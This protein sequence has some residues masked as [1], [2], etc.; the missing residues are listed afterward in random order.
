[1]SQYLGTEVLTGC[2]RGWFPCSGPSVRRGKAPARTA[3]FDPQ[4]T[5][6][7]CQPQRQFSARL[8]CKTPLNQD[9]FGLP[10]QTINRTL[11]AA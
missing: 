10:V 1:M 6:S 11:R 9:Q 2:R 5:L 8:R 4:P 3:G 7:W